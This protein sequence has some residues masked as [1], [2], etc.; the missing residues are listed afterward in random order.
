MKKLFLIVL[1]CITVMVLFF[2]CQTSKTYPGMVL[3]PAGS[4]MMGDA[5]STNMEKP[6]HEVEV[7]AF[8]MDTHEVTIEEFKNFVD[9][10]HYVTDTEKKDGCIIWN[11]KGWEKSEGINWR[12]DELG[13][14]HK[15][16]K[17]NHPVTHL[18]WNDANAYAQWAG[19]RLGPP[20]RN[21]NTSLEAGQ[22]ATSTRGAPIP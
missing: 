9:A 16:D 22:K 6:V 11:G 8:Y 12:F 4:F 2:N 14:K 17:E 18:S 20:R 21:G 3:I 15:T 5:N 10:T 1:T 7:D 19:K 13:I